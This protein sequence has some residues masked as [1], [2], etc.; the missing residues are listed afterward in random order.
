MDCDS[1]SLR[2]P[3]RNGSLSRHS[4]AQAA[5][6]LA[7]HWQSPTDTDPVL[8]AIQY[9]GVLR[10]L[11]SQPRWISLSHIADPPGQALSWIGQHIHLVNRQLGAILEDLLDCFEEQQRPRVQ[12]FAAPIAPL[13]GVDGFCSNGP[14]PAWS[15]PCVLPIT[16]MVDP[17]RIVRADWPGLVAHELAHG[18]AG[19]G[20]HGVEFRRAIAH[21]C[22]AQDL[23]VPPPDL[24]A[25]ALSYWP[26]CRQSPQP[27][28]FWLGQLPQQA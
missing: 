19:L 14:G 8:V 15:E 25:E 27:E 16:L 2:E 11:A 20:G 9:L 4:S 6:Y 10:D 28:S 1:R 17:G 22:L 21:L 13:A 26:P 3:P 23:P 7:S 12:I 24:N 18:V 5:Q